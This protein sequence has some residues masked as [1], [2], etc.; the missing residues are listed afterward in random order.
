MEIVREEVFGPVL[1]VMSFSDEQEAIK[2]ANSGKYGLAASVWT[3]DISRAHRFAAHIRAGR[4]GINCHAGP[5]VTMPTGGYK[6]SGWGRELGPE[7]ID[8]FLETKAIQV[9]L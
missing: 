1:S 3:S 6:E 5:N 4:I 2:M 7:G 8:A 9:K